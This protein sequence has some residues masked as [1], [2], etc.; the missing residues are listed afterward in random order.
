MSYNV[1]GELYFVF[2]LDSAP[3]GGDRF[4]TVIRLLEREISTRPQVVPAH[5]YLRLDG[6]L[7][8]HS[9]QREIS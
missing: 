1:E 7:F 4:D 2:D 5:Y 8:C 3:G 9:M 6:N